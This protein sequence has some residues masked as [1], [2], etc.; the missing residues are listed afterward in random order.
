M[1]RVGS[2]SSQGQP[3]LSPAVE[4]WVPAIGA[5]RAYERRW[6]RDDL[7]AAL[8]LTALLV[9][10]GMAYAELAGLPAVTGLYTTIASLVGYAV[11]GPSRILVLGPDSSLAPVIA[12]IIAPL[13]IG[14][15]PSEA[16]ALAAILAILAGLI[17]ILAG[18]LRL[19]TITDLLSMPVRVGYLNGIALLVL[20]SQLPKLFGF[21][22]DSDGFVDGIEQFVRGVIDGDTVGVAL[23]L[24]TASIL[25]IVLGRR[26]T[27]REPRRQHA[28]EGELVSGRVEDGDDRRRHHHGDEH[29]G[30]PAGLSSP[31]D[32]EEDAG[33]AECQGDADGVA[34]DHTADELLDA[35]DESVG[36]GAEA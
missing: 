18:L 35:V 32:D 9:P 36:V 2:S 8:V 1:A 10:Q 27:R 22:T 11:F 16:V 33:G 30:H 26:R 29:P 25:L 23:A 7:V 31:E 13:I 19:G 21:S 6:I 24:G 3:R 17:E 14:D 5:A 15:S 34:V 4:R 12:A 28:D 20:V